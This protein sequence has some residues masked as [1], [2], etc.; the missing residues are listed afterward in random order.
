MVNRLGRKC[1]MLSGLYLFLISLFLFG[2]IEYANAPFFFVLAGII[3]R[4]LLGVGSFQHKTV[5]Y[6]VATKKF[7]KK[8]D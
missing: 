2:C 5:L 6:S 1:V 4:F 3:T 7:P 8:V